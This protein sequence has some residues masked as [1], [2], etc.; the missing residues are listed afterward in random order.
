MP[1][2]PMNR[3]ETLRLFLA[4]AVP[5]A[6]KAELRR[7]QQELQP[8]LPSQAV[9]WTRPEQF[10]L[11]LKFLGNVPAENVEVLSKAAREVCSSMLPLRLRAEG[12]GFFP[13][14][15]SPRVFWVEIKS[16]GRELLALQQQLEA[17]VERFAEKSEAKK[18]AAHVTLARF[19]RLRRNAVEKFIMRARADKQFGEWTAKEI[20]LVQSQLMPTGALHAILGTFRTKND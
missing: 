16:G 11:T 15:F 1:A 18:F 10:H 8:L 12:T 4:I 19:E 3:K 7:L 14:D 2:I 17:A 20:I 13:N 6:V 9:R 5:E